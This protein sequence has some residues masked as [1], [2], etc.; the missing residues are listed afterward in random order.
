M[1]E[2][3]DLKGLVGLLGADEG[4]DLGVWDRSVEGVGHIGLETYTSGL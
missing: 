3:R 4:G 2:R 1:D